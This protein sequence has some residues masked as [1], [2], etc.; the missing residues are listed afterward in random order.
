MISPARDVALDI[1]LKVEQGGFASDLLHSERLAKLTTQ[2]RALATELVMGVQR[3]R[4]RLDEAIA[5]LASQALGKLDA[6]VLES[7]RLA[8]YQ[9]GFLS[10]IPAHAAVNDSV[11]LVKRKKKKSA[12]PFVNAVLRK[13]LAKKEL[14]GPLMSPGQKT[15]PELSAL[16]AHP[17]WLVDRWAAQYGLERAEAI[18]AYNQQVPPAAIH[19]FGAT[20]EQEL[21]TAGIELVPGRLL[22]SARVITNGDVTSTAAFREGRVQIQ[23]EGSQLV[24]LLAGQGERLLDCCAAPGGKTAILAE[25][26]PQAEI[27]AIELHEHRARALRE[28]LRHCSNVNVMAADAVR[29]DLPGGFDRA[30]ADVPCSGTGTLARNPEIKWRLAPEDLIDLHRRQVA[31]LRA[32]LAKLK[33]GG[34]LVYSTCSLE[35][36]ENQAVIEESGAAV[37]PVNEELEALSRQDTLVADDS[38]AFTDGPFLRLFPGEFGTDGFFAA[39][40]T[41]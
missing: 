4:S 40:L 7:L 21:V 24:A 30:L 26:N 39:V 13:L 32:A 19:L 25:R 23:D 11:E 29:V 41:R 8:A 12:A 37:L 38:A 9:I 31:I 28:R 27:V 17:L 35:P 10:R 15:I 22:R 33:P 14:L 18:C 20:V 2:D 5:S 16:Y 6:E 34:R 36:E 1:L 3:W